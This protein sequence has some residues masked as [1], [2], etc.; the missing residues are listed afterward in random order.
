MSP[1]TG[2]AG[3]VFQDIRETVSAAQIWDPSAR[4]LPNPAADVSVQA[5]APH[6][7]I[8]KPWRPQPAA[9]PEPEAWLGLN[10]SQQRAVRMVLDEHRTLTFIQGPPGTGKTT[11]AIE[12]VRG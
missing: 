3:S 10:P 5:R 7:P 12:I 11:T 6:P 2:L 8:H 4:P 9:A 1:G